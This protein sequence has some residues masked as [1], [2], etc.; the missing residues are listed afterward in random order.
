MVTGEAKGASR[1]VEAGGHRLHFLEYGDPAQPQLVI[2]PGI[3]SP[4]ITWEFVA[5]E[6]APDFHVLTM[7][8]R[9]RGLSDIGTGF[10]L[11][12]LAQDVAGSVEA[13]GLD[14][15]AVLGHSAGA[16]VAAAFGVLYPDLRGP[17]IVADPPL[18][19]P[20]RAPYPTPLEPF[21]ESIRQARAGATAD[22]MRA[23]FPTWTD[24]QLELRAEWL[25][26]CDETA[27]SEVHRLFHEEDLF[28][29]WPGLAPP[30]LLI[31]AGAAPVVG[32]EGAAELAA[33]NP[34]A[35]VVELA[36]SGHMLPW[37]DLVGFL[38]IVRGFLAGRARR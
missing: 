21:V 22:D 9:G 25:G 31:W 30:A 6:L 28:E 32:P 18:S 3:T 14:R 26:S 27:V 36:G 1:W 7:D 37:D 4:A 10:T 24:E 5:L 17:V 19:G 13:L 16:R 33:A 12:D 29:W 34:S 2:L 38:E 35:K 20:G 11:P 23:Y 8:L 15:P